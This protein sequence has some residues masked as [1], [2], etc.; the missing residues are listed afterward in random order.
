MGIDEFDSSRARKE[1]KSKRSDRRKLHVR[2]RLDADAQKI[3][4]CA[5]FCDR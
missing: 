4:K 5:Q 2:K 1:D 3:E